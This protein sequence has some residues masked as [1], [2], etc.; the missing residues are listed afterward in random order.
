MPGCKGGVV[1]S[2]VKVVAVRLCSDGKQKRIDERVH[3]KIDVLRRRRERRIG[4]GRRQRESRRAAVLTVLLAKRRNGRIKRNRVG[5]RGSNHRYV[6]AAVISDIDFIRHRIDRD[7]KGS[8]ASRDGCRRV[9]CPVNYRYIV[10]ICISDID[11][12]RRRI[13]RD[14]IGPE[15]AATVV[16][17]LFVPSITVTFAL[18]T[19]AT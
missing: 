16:V 1:A 5:R 2:A 12:V 14:G 11:F 17:E 19:L 8:C 7:V 10:V 4:R 9:V 15:P 13:D 18:L 3:L 6:V